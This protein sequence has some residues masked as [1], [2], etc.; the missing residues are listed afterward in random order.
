MPEALIE[1]ANLRHDQFY[2]R[3]YEQFGWRCGF[4]PASP[5]RDRESIFKWHRDRER[6][7]IDLISR[8]A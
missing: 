4:E 5:K 1:Q 6:F 7:A 3:N 8:W 2:G